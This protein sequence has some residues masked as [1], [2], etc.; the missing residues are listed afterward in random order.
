MQNE[1]F[2]QGVELMVYGMGVVFVFLLL[3]IVV[4]VLMSFILQRFFP[5]PTLID[6]ALTHPASP[7]S[8]NGHDTQPLADDHLLALMTAAIHQHRQRNKR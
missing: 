7:V 1:L 6:S 2:Q 3:L 5:D 4:T 8:Q